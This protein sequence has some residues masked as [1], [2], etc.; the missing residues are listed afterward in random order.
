MPVVRPHETTRSPLDGFSWY[1]KRRMFRKSVE[2]FRVSVKSDKNNGYLA[3]RPIYI[4][5]HLTLNPSYCEKCFRQ[6][7]DSKSKHIFL[8]CSI[9]P[10]E[11]L[12]VYDTI[13]KNNV[14]QDRPQ[15]TI[16]SMRMACWTPTAT[17]AHSNTHCFSTETMVART[18]SMLPL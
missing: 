10:P 2:N 15:M 14:E 16:R 9:I 4:S 7:L 8:A 6:K 13:W 12:A 3:W 11:N 17:N 5:D 18:S 1:L